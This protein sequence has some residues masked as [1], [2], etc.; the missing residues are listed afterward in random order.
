ML[1]IVNLRVSQGD[2]N[3]LFEDKDTEWLVGQGSFQIS[4]VINLLSCWQLY[5]V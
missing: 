5:S 4:M 2:E 1:G 3:I